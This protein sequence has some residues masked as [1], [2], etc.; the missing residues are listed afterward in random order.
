MVSR[1]VVREI[2]NLTYNANINKQLEMSEVDLPWKLSR[3]IEFHFELVRKKREFL[4]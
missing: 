2:S 4:P 3:I 1:Q